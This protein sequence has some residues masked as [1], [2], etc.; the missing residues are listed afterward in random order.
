MIGV[1]AT[2]IVFIYYGISVPYLLTN[3]LYTGA[4]G[5]I[6]GAIT[7]R[8]RRLIVSAL[9][10]AA[11]GFFVGALRYKG[12]AGGI[13]VAFIRAGIPG[14]PTGAI[15]G[16]IFGVILRKLKKWP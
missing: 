3:V 15:L 14:A 8:H 7:G 1:A 2:A 11:V 9:V 10:G 6:A 5:A 4:G 13:L 16:A 12:F